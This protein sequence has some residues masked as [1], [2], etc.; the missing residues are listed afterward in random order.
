MAAIR[1]C[2]QYWGRYG[3]YAASRERREERRRGGRHL[4]I[5]AGEQEEGIAASEANAKHRKT[6]SRLDEATDQAGER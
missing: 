4:R 1:D 5:G 2:D 3:R 6:Q